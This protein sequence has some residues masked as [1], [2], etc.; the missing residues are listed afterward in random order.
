LNRDVPTG[1]VGIE[2]FLYDPNGEA[3]NLFFVRISIYLPAEVAV[4][5]ALRPKLGKHKMGKSV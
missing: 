4:Q 2:R 3:Y 1:V 5:K